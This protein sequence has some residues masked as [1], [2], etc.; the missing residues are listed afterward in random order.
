MALVRDSFLARNRPNVTAG[1]MCPPDQKPSTYLPRFRVISKQRKC[2]SGEKGKKN[3]KQKV[4]KKG[5][6][7]EKKRKKKLR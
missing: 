6:N 3:L 5:S 1:F 2:K 4:G 7:T